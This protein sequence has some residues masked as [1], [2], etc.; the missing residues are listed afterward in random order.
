MLQCVM[1]GWGYFAK[2]PVAKAI[3]ELPGER[4]G[5]VAVEIVAGAAIAAGG[6][7]FGVSGGV[8]DIA[9]R[10]VRRTGTKACRSECGWR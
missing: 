7:R 6:A 10:S 8:L 9:Q 3:A 4:V 5:R 2:I 1:F